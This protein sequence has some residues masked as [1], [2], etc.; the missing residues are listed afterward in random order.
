[1]DGECAFCGRGESASRP[2]FCQDCQAEHRVCG[3]CADEAVKD[4]SILGLEL[5]RQVA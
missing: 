2:I 4:L 1:M 5:D 3:A